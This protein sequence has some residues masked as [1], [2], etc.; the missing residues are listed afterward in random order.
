MSLK[1]ATISPAMLQGPVLFCFHIS[2]M[3]NGQKKESGVPLIV[4]GNSSC[5][6]RMAFIA[7][8]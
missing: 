1:S 6:V 8:I 7:L 2:N 4:L 3:V 5:G